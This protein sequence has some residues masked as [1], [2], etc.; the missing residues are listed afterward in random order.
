MDNIT[1]QYADENDLDRFLFAAVG[2]DRN[3]NTVTVLSTLARIGLDPRKEAADLAV[4]SRKKAQI[5]LASLLTDFNDVPS[6]DSDAAATRL[7]KLLPK[8]GYRSSE[9]S[10]PSIYKMPVISKGTI[11]AIFII[12]LVF[13][14]LFGFGIFN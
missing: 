12:V 4:M 8:H 9:P 10:A 2:E 1:L 6:L 3:G 11:L 5:R 13:A 14:E 7:T